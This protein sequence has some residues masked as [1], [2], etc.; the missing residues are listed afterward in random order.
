MSRRVVVVGAGQAAA[1]FVRALRQGGFTGSIRMLGRERFPPYERPPLSKKF[2]EGS[3]APERVFLR[4]RDV[5]ERIGVELSTDATVTS[6]DPADKHVRL[7]DGTSI[8]FDTCVLATGCDARHPRIPGIDLDGILVLRTIDDALNLRETLRSR[9]R[10]VIAGGGYLG[11]EV[12][13][14]ARKAGVD[15]VVIEGAAALMQRSISPT[16]AAMIERKHGAEGTRLF[17]ETTL[18]AI[19]GETKVEA[20]ITSRGDSIETETVLISVGGKPAT[21]LAEGCGLRCDNG[22]LVDERCRTSAADIYAM[23]DCANQLHPLYGRHL[24]LEAVNSALFHAR[25]AAADLLGKPLP[26]AKPPSFWSEQC[27]SMLQI[28]GVP[29]PGQPC[30]DELRGDDKAFAVYRFQAGELVAVEALNRPK[31]FVRAHALIGQRD[32]LLPTV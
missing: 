21:E 28:V 22:I 20:V 5:Y 11:L 15:V 12:A 19:R 16:A 10:L 1:E 4:N 31:D 8:A 23:G 18:T 24:R 7:A 32:I 30:E 17:L 26:P 6:I 14:S 3:I 29:R 9:K 13:S 27:G 25:S 2:L